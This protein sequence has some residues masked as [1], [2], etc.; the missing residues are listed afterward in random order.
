MRRLAIRLLAFFR[1]ISLL[2]QKLRGK[3]PADVAERRV[4]SGR[5]LG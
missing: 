4:I 2:I 3:T 5:S 1:R